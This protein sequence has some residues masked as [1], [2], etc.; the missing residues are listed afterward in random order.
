[1]FWDSGC[2]S[3][4]RLCTWW[5]EIP[6]KRKKMSKGEGGSK[7]KIFEHAYFLNGA[8]STLSDGIPE[9]WDPGPSG[10]TRDLGPLNGTLWWNPRVGH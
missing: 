5:R 10:G 9:K 3:L 7:L 6:Q 2:D 4:K 1:M 8:F